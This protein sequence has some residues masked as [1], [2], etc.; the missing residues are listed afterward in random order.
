MEFSKGE[1]TLQGGVVPDV[2]RDLPRGVLEEDVLRFDRERFPLGAQIVRMLKCHASNVGKFH[3]EL[4]GE[5]EDSECWLRGFRSLEDVDVFLSFKNGLRIKDMVESNQPFLDVFERLVKEVLCPYLYERVR[6]ESDDPAFEK[7]QFSYQYPPTLR[8][9]NGNTKMFRRIHRDAEYGHQSGELNFW[10]PLTNSSKTK[11]TIWTETEPM[12]GDLHPVEMDYGELLCFF[13][14]LCRHRVPANPSPFTR[15]SIDFRIGFGPCFD[16]DYK[17]PG[18]R[19]H[20]QR[21]TFMYPS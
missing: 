3:E 12:R 7:I 18:V 8:I 11:T 17:M 19:L 16:K 6:R 2:T 1:R 5:S 4:I 15:V 20:H 21:R 13:G 10:L 14:T 9:Q